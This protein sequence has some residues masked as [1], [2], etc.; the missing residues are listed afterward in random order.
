MAQRK[1]RLVGREGRRFESCWGRAHG[2]LTLWT[3]PAAGVRVPN[4]GGRRDIGYAR[5]VVKVTLTAIEGRPRVIEFGGRRW[6]AAE[7]RRVADGGREALLAEF[8]EVVGPGEAGADV[9]AG[10][11]GLHA[12]IRA[13]SGTGGRR[14]R[15][16]RAG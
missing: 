13:G 16:G 9:L 11:P 8:A 12:R 7:Q 6:K 4:Q 5:N 10:V 14:G 15:R 1:A 2:T 3:M